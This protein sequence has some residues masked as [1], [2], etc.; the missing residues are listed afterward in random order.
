MGAGSKWGTKYDVKKL[1]RTEFSLKGTV[2]TSQKKVLEL[3]EKITQQ[4][5]L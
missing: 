4:C 5:E 2:G 1:I 3:T